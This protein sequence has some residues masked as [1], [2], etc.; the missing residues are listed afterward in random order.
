M[1]RVTM[2]RLEWQTAGTTRLTLC[3]GPYALKFARSQRGRDGNRRERREWKRATPERRQMLCP[4]L[5]SAPFGFVNVM[6]RAI[7]LTRHE[8]LALLDSD[9]FPDWDYMPGGPGEPFEYK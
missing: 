4:L 8:Q 1:R 5:W 3:V 9:G 7:P 6:R 2:L